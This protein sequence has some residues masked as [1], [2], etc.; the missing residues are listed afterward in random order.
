MAL[1]P[2]E[3]SLRA[4]QETRLTN[5]QVDANFQNLANAADAL[6]GAVVNDETT[7]RNIAAADAWKWTRLTEAA[8]VVLGVPVGLNL[9]SAGKASFFSAGA[10]GVTFE[11]ADGVTVNTIGLT[12]PQFRAATLVQVGTDIFDLIGGLE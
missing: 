2:V 7:G 10:G 3:I 5:D 8:N 9:G 1:F 4:D 12:L 11:P 6:S